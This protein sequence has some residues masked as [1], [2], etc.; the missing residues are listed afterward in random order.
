MDSPEEPAAGGSRE[1]LGA[2]APRLCASATPSPPT[3]SATHGQ[4]APPQ[5]R[6]RPL[7]LQMS[8]GLQN[9]RR[10][11]AEIRVLMLRG[12]MRILMS[13]MEAL[14]SID[15]E[16][17]IIEVFREMVSLQAVFLKPERP[18]SKLI[19]RR[20][21]KNDGLVSPNIKSNKKT[22]SLRIRGR[23]K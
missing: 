10:A 7:P 21:E 18:K 19:K 15:I 12:P 11:S 4:R 3:N 8:N 23:W 6:R 20:K 9:Q 16:S 17:K 22:R 13:K 2:A 1:P 14:A 5:A